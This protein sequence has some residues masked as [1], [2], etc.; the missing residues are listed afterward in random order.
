MLD[1]LVWNKY[2]RIVL[3]LAR[4]LNTSPLEALRLFYNSKVYS[5][6]LDKSYPLITLSDAY[7]VDEI[8][9]SLTK[10]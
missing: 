4:R 10:S 3:L 9:F 6:L 8:I 5:S 2:S 1:V 7:I